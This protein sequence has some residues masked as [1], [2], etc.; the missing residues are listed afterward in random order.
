MA[1]TTNNASEKNLETFSQLWLD[2][3]ANESREN[4]AAQEQLRSTINHI[5]TF[6][7]DNECAEYIRNA[8][9][10]RIVLIVGGQIGKKIVPKIHD[11]YQLFSIYIYCSDREK[12]K[13]WSQNFIKVN[14]EV[15]NEVIRQE[16]LTYSNIRLLYIEPLIKVS[17]FDLTFPFRSV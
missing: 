17:V 10:D 4:R 11:L 5:Q 14:S 12:H 13:H 3:T 15:S 7:N 2:A 8:V 9:S 16:S 6:N 1:S